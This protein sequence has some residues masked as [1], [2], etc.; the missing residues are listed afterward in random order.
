[1]RS[2]RTPYL[3]ISSAYAHSRHHEHDATMSRS[4]DFM[5]L[6]M[7]SRVQNTDVTCAQQDISRHFDHFRD[8][9]CSRFDTRYHRFR[10]Q[11]WWLWSHVISRSEHVMS[12]CMHEYMYAPYMPINR[13]IMIPC[14]QH[15][16]SMHASACNPCRCGCQPASGGSQHHFGVMKCARDFV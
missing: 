11:I 16:V 13:H 6:A 14:I 1:M 9:M 12:M 15:A 5:L 10:A 7:K 8:Q 3:L 4:G 2:C